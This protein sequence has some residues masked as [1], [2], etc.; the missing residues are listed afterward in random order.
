MTQRTPPEPE[1]VEI[2]GYDADWPE[3]FRA[4][5]G[6]IR[7]A[8]GD[9]AIR[10]DHIGSTAVPGLAA[11]PVIDI[12]L[13]VRSFGPSAAY[14]APLE[15]LG[16]RLLPDP[17]E[18]DH[19]FYRRPGDRPRRTNV[20]VCVSGGSWERRHLLFR[21]YLRSHREEADAYETLKREM[22]LRLGENRYEYTDAKGS[23]I[24]E[25]QRRAEEW[26]ATTGWAPAPS[27]A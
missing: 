13:S 27:D 19:R 10:I 23:F 2:V 17:E 5:A 25:A 6:A 24:R 18:P 12:Q 14:E 16:Y 9:T 22:A 15:G 20:H 26:A 21:D 8:L 3:R 1:P 4:E 7:Q 11:K